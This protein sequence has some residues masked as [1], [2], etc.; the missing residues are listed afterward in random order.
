MGECRPAFLLGGGQHNRLW[1]DER[2][3][4]VCPPTF[5]RAEEGIHQ[6]GKREFFKKLSQV[7]FQKSGLFEYRKQGAFRQVFGMTRHG[8][9]TSPGR[10]KENV[11]AAG[12][13]F[14]QETIFLERGDDIAGFQ[15]GK[16]GHNGAVCVSIG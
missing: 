2:K 12:G 1:E 14:V 3:K 7:F 6:L 4:R 13:M 11:M 9:N 16:F 15:D 5:F 10:M 8:H